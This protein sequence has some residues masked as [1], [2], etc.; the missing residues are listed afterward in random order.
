MAMTGLSGQNPIV[1]P[2]R[3][4]VAWDITVLTAATTPKNQQA[5]KP[6]RL[7]PF[8]GVFSH[9]MRENLQQTGGWF[10]R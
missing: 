1:R 9:V 4:S 6:A 5:K 8:I 10:F 2:V 3:T 7:Q